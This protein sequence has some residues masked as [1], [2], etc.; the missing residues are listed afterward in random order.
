MFIQLTVESI[1][2]IL[3]KLANYINVVRCDTN[4]RK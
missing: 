2:N 4:G 3:D 1:Y